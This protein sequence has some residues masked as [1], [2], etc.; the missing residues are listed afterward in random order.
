MRRA[1]SSRKTCDFKDCAV[2]YHQGKRVIG[3]AWDT[4]HKFAAQLDS[5][6]HTAKRL[7]GA[8]S[9]LLQHLG[10]PTNKAINALNAIW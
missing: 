5:G 10:Q 2:R 9:P 7:Y 3:H 4:T 8:L 6:I 1:L